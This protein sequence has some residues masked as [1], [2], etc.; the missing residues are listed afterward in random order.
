MKPLRRALTVLLMTSLIFWPIA[1]RRPHP[2]PSNQPAELA[3]KLYADVIAH[4][5]SDIPSGDD[6]NIFAP[7]LSKSLLRDI[8]IYKA[9][10]ADEERHYAALNGPPVKLASLA[11]SGIF[12]GSDEAGAPGTAQVESSQAQK[13]GTVRV[14]VKLGLPQDHTEWRVIDL[15]VNEDG[16]FV[17]EDVVFPGEFYT[18]GIKDDRPLGPDRYLSQELTGFCKGGTHWVGP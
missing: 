3:Q 2:T 13:D 5:T 8:D 18:K 6:W 7:F 14:T 1:C 4:P 17:L 11:E 16:R 9:C 15:F 10:I 12:S